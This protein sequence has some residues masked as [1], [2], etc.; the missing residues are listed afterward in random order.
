[1]ASTARSSATRPERANALRLAI[2][3]ALAY[4]AISLVIAMAQGGNAEWFVKLGKNDPA[5]V[6]RAREIL[7]HEDVNVPFV[8][9]HDGQYYWLVARDPL[10]LNPGDMDRYFDSATYRTQRI[11]YPLTAAPFRLGGEQALLWGLVLSNLIAVGIGTYLTSRLASELR[12]PPR[13]GLAFAA[14]P[15]VLVGVM[16]DLPDVWALAGLVGAVLAVRRGRWGWAL[17]AGTVTVMSREVML[18]AV[19]GVAV[20]AVGRPV[21]ARVRLVAVPTVAAGAWFLYTHARMT[22]GVNVATFVAIPFSGWLDAYLNSWSAYDRWPDFVVALV[23]LLVTIAVIVRFFRRRTLE[24]WAA[25]PLAALLPF[26][27]GQV[28]SNSTNSTRT[29]GASITLLVLDMYANRREVPVRWP[30]IPGR[31]PK[32]ALDRSG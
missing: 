18:A 3:A 27:H 4:L 2:G 9:H 12:A 14:N 32:P 19:L 11:F 10:L 8:D 7:G 5:M 20:G 24:L 13:A 1:M 6:Q 30:R 16:L 23:V 22:T 28:I 29:L 17:V 15:L 26:T 31:T 21:W 25:A